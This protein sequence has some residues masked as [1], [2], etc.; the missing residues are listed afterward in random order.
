MG[1]GI[2]VAQLLLS[3]AGSF[4]VTRKSLARMRKSIA[5]RDGLG[6]QTEPRSWRGTC[7]RYVAIP[8][9]TQLMCQQINSDTV[10]WRLSALY[11][12]ESSLVGDQ[13][14]CTIA[15]EDIPLPTGQPW[16]AAEASH[17]IL[18]HTE[19]APRLHQEEMSKTIPGRVATLCDWC[20]YC[21]GEVQYCA[22]IFQRDK[23]I[24]ALDT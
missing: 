5:R 23:R 4:T 10:W 8:P 19:G 20:S 7:T 14:D 1:L 12:K 13:Q 17:N 16:K 15:F 11:R 9:T 22:V 3:M 24:Q 6:S 18:R 2:R 21:Q